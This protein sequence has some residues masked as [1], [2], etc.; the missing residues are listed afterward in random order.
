MQQHSKNLKKEI[1][2]NDIIKLTDLK[3][4]K[5]S[6]YDLSNAYKKIENIEEDIKDVSYNLENLVDYAISY[7]QKILDIYGK[8]HQRKTSIEKFD[9]I[10]ARR[11]AIANKKL[12][13]NRKDGFV[14]FD[15]KH[16]EFISE[17]SE[18]DNIIVFLKNGTYIVSKVESK[19]YI[20]NDI[21]HVAVWK[22]ND[23]HMVYN[24]VY[25]D[26]KTG[27]FYVKRF[28]IKSAIKDR[29]YS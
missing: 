27:W 16:D 8:K 7:Y 28:S 21:L 22:K 6:K 15:I 9:N 1:T 19:K 25:K 17:C 26:S 10:S 20:G 29:Y 4:K 3:I 11:V 14:G 13:V 5:I 18:L 12:Y 24:Y 23:K 2:A